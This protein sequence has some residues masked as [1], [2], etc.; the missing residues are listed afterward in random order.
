MITL[1]EFFEVTGSR[2]TEG[3][4]YGWNCFGSNAYSLS[5]WN[6]DPDGWSAD[7]VFDTRT[8]EVYQMNFCDYSRQRA[9]RWT[10]PEYL[11]AYKKIISEQEIDDAAWESVQ[12]HDVEVESD[13]LEKTRACFSGQDYD[14]RVTLQVDFPDD[15][16]FQAMQDAHKRDI[17]F[18][19]WVEIAL[20]AA[21]D[22][23]ENSKVAE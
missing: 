21:I 2:I 8:Q 12:Y 16:L 7:V 14:N 22:E 11:D 10:N 5:A 19:Q 1:K 9:Y 20:Q 18:N 17:T 6:G 23:Y 3:S 15:V 4:D 13:I